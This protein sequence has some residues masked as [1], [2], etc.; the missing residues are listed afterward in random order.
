MDVKRH[1]VDSCPVERDNLDRSG[2][3]LFLPTWWAFSSSRRYSARMNSSVLAAEVVRS[4][5]PSGALPF[6]NQATNR[7]KTGNDDRRS[8]NRLHSPCDRLDLGEDSEAPAPSAFFTSSP[9]GAGK[10]FC[11]PPGNA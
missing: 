9:P 3:L 11:R 2:V 10:G 8:L 7:Q 4:D 5:R 1:P 6:A